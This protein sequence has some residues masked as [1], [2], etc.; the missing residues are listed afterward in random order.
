MPDH[1]RRPML[2]ALSIVGCFA[3]VGGALGLFYTRNLFSR[4]PL[5]ILLQVAAVVLLVWARITFGRRSFH[6]TAGPTEGGL[7]STGPY[8]YIRHPIYASVCLFVWA[9]VAAHWLGETALCGGLVLGGAVVRMLCEEALVAKR[10]PEYR[11]YAETTWRM[12]P[13]VF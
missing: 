2:N 13:Y 8:R 10:Y 5:V 9:S 1:N 12:V 3:M 6:F 11:Q 7:V 4:S